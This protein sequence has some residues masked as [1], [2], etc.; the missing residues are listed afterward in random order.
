MSVWVPEHQRDTAYY[1]CRSLFQCR[2][3]YIHTVSVDYIKLFGMPASGDPAHDRAMASELTIRMLS[4]DK[5]AELYKNGVTVRLV[6]YTDA[7]VIYEH[8]SNHL[9]AWKIH[10]ENGLNIRHAPIDDLVLLDKFAVAVY[11]HAKYQFTTEMVDSILARRMSTTMR[12]NR[13]TI[14][15]RKEPQVTVINGVE[16]KEEVKL[17]ERTSMAATFA[18]YAQSS[19]PKWK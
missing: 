1:I 14:L 10:L 8:I 6:K 15:R 19:R 3:P 12:A 17:P 13:N 4:I 16:V 18:Q 5:M 9:N 7:K 11:A 2:V